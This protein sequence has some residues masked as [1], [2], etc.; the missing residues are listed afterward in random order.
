MKHDLPARVFTEVNEGNEEVA[1]SSFPL[2]PSV[3]TQGFN[4]SVLERGN[5]E[6]VAGGN[7]QERTRFAPG[8]PGCSEVSAAG[9]SALRSP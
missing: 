3:T 2:L 7:R 6:P 8:A 9:A 4:L 1:G 5:F